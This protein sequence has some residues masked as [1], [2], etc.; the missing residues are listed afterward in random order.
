MRICSDDK[1]YKLYRGNAADFSCSSFLI[2]FLLQLGRFSLWTTAKNPIASRSHD[3]AHSISQFDVDAVYLQGCGPIWHARAA[4][5]D[6]GL[7]GRRK[8]HAVSV[9]VHS[10]DLIFAGRHKFY[11]GSY[12][13]VA[14]SRSTIS[15]SSICHADK[16]PRRADAEN[17]QNRFFRS[18]TAYCVHIC[19]CV[20]A[21]VLCC[22]LESVDCVVGKPRGGQ[23]GLEQRMAEALGCDG[24][25]QTASVQGL[26]SQTLW[27]VILSSQSRTA[28][29]PTWA[30][31][32]D[33]ADL[34]K[35]I[36]S[37]HFGVCLRGRCLRTASWA[38]KSKP[39]QTRPLLNST[40]T[41]ARDVLHAPGPQFVVFVDTS[42]RIFWSFGELHHQSRTRGTGTRALRGR[43]KEIGGRR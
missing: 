23:F 31:Y 40:K 37:C 18:V 17:A 34:K 39:A 24:Q 11:V 2:R 41:Y 28:A 30:L 1:T 33:H 43:R 16:V 36:G 6:C 25:I 13:E 14:I 29:L 38:C 8:L 9:C 10:T 15:H 12:G 26:G 5:I 19:R 27:F 32:L 21:L 4:L 3:L 35:A 42:R 22:L 7:P 20:F